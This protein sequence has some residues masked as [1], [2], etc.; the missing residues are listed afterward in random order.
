[1]QSFKKFIVFS[2]FLVLPNLCAAGGPITFEPLDEKDYPKTVYSV[3]FAGENTIE[4]RKLLQLPDDYRKR[5]NPATLFSD[6]VEV[7]ETTRDICL[8]F[9]PNTLFPGTLIPAE[10]PLDANNVFISLLT[11]KPI[12]DHNPDTFGMLKE[13]SRQANIMSI[14]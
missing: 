10:F 3:N 7:R 12:P 13:I 5:V 6:I 2:A 9:S 8:T 1:M 14:L 11:N 4:G